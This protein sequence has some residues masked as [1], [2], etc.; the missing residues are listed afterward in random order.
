MDQ[1]K[2]PK[3]PHH[4]KNRILL[5]HHRRTLD[6]LSYIQAFRTREVL[7]VMDSEIFES[8]QMTH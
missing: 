7:T 5:V 2:H 8:L 6:F 1:H 3:N 4:Y